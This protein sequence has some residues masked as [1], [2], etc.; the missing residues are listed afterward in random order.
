MCAQVG[1]G[2]GRSV[3]EWMLRSREQLVAIVDDA[4]GSQISRKL[5]FTNVTESAKGSVDT[6]RGNGGEGN[7]GVRVGK[8]DDVQIDVR[9]NSVECLQ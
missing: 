1:K 4:R 9:V 2:H 7:V 8:R 6:A 3:R 5:L